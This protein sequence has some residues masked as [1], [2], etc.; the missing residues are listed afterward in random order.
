MWLVRKEVIKM[1][2]EEFLRAL[3]LVSKE[4]NVSKEIIIEG[5]KQALCTAY[6][7]N[8]AKTNVRVD[9]DESTGDFKVISYLVVVDE[10]IEPT[11]ETNEEGEEV[12]LP[13]EI[14]EDAQILLE[15]AQKIDPDIKVGES[16]EKEVTPA[17]RKSTRLN[18]SHQII[19]YAV[20]CLK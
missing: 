18:S 9:F 6:K 16:I 4:K 17:D 2:G 14:P 8:N 13:P 7:K 10:Y 12:E 3:D 11:Y 1:N 19:S 20:F 15:D 5:M